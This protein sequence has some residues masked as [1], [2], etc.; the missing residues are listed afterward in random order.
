MPTSITRKT[1]REENT[2]SPSGRLED[3]IKM[4]LKNYIVMG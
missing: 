4:D 1:D 2:L 3:S